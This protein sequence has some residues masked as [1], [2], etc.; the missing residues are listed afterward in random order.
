MT[1]QKK[2][3]KALNRMKSLTTGTSA[4]EHLTNV[5]KAIL[6]NF[7]IGAGIASL[8]SDYIPS[9]K[10]ERLTEFAEKA[11]EDLKRLS[12]E[13][14]EER[15]KTD[16]FAFVFEECFAGASRHYQKE[17]LDAFRAIL[18]NSAVRSDFSGDESEFFL[19]LVN[20]LSVL[21][22]R[23]LWFL[24]NPVEYLRGR[25]IERSTVEGSDFG[26][27]ME[28]LFYPANREMLRS[29]LEDLKAHALIRLVEVDIDAMLK[30][31]PLGVRVHARPV[32]PL[33]EKFIAFCTNPT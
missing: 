12:D 6:A 2:Y 7:P 4:R 23:M 5:M 15:L 20:S 26:T 27:L 33:G 16:S 28:K 9:R 22:L 32:S 3:D 13:V 17:K 24:S 8:M 14:L 18:V 11:A 10:L 25:G 21:H 30:Q 31:Y 19:Q 1:E 29:V